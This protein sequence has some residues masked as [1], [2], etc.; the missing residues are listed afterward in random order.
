MFC[1]REA[2]NLIGCGV[3][4]DLDPALCQIS[5]YL[6]NKKKIK[7]KNYLSYHLSYL[8]VMMSVKFE[9]KKKH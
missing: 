1:N 7:K 4:D 2:G 5:W 3:S 6:L 9:V 8:K